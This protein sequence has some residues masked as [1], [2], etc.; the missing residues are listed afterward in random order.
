MQVKTITG[1]KKPSYPDRVKLGQTQKS[2]G[3]AIPQAWQRHTLVT[4][5]LAT[6]LIM[7]TGQAAKPQF[8]EVPRVHIWEDT[9]PPPTPRKNPK[10]RK[11]SKDLFKEAT[12]SPAFMY[13]EGKGTVGCSI[14]APSVF[15][16]E[17]E[18]WDIVST[19][20]AQ[21]KI[22]LYKQTKWLNLD[23]GN[24]S[25]T[26]RRDD[27]CCPREYS[28]QISGTYAPYNL[29]VCILSFTDDQSIKNWFK[30]VDNIRE[31]GFE[32]FRGYDYSE[33]ISRLYSHYTTYE[34]PLSV[35]VACL[36]PPEISLHF[37]TDSGVDLDALKEGLKQSL[38]KQ[39][40]AFLYWFGKQGYPIPKT[41]E[42]ERK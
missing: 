16:S 12:Y 11:H 39:V 10:T 27:M 40:D 19:R 32:T 8:P 4:S 36:Y 21:H 13:G 23:T 35:N 29:G 41:K 28:I 38:A 18:A 7:G 31:D 42:I 25:D 22:P 33:R 26:T 37:S 17:N 3:W 2:L 24:L 1:Y 5:L 15:L 20:F 30:K 6:Y 34:V 9:Y 14:M